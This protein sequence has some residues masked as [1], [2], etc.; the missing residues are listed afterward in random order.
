M[1][2]S[3]L[4]GSRSSSRSG[5][6]SSSSSR[7]QQQPQPQHQQQQP[8]AASSSQQQQGHGFL[9]FLSSSFTPPAL[10]SF[11][12]RDSL[13]VTF[14]VALPAAYGIFFGSGCLRLLGVRACGLHLHGRF[15]CRGPGPL[16]R[17]VEILLPSPGLGG[18]L[19]RPACRHP[20]GSDGHHGRRVGAG[21]AP[22]IRGHVGAGRLPRVKE[23][24]GVGAGGS[25]RIA[26]RDSRAGLDSLSR[27][28]RWSISQVDKQMDRETDRW[29]HHTNKLIG[30]KGRSIGRS[31]KI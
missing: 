24:S 3:G 2:V 6:G 8:P 14:A 27:S 28:D 20:H 22:P 19:W 15:V 16:H 30:Q 9:F 7:Q 18:G 23:A 11:F 29:I 1:S 17:E 31:V 4:F 21:P 25:R 5:S 12:S 13:H 10:F 26:A